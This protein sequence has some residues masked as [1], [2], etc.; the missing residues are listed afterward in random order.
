MVFV[1]VFRHVPRPITGMI[2]VLYDRTFEAFEAN[3]DWLE[4][5]GILVERFDPSVAAS[6]VATRAVV[7]QLLSAE[8]DACL[9]LILVNNAV[10]SRGA[11]PSR[12]QLAR[13]VGRG[14][15]TVRQIAV[16]GALA[17]VGSAEELQAE[18]TRAR[19]LGIDEGAVRMATDTGLSLRQRTRSAA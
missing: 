8:G 9:P 2:G 4:T 13:A 11:H 6:E 18:T 1:T 17:A 7:Q 5:T 15:A 16:L 12:T 19:D 14:P 10:V 3:L